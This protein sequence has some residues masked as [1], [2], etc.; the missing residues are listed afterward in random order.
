MHDACALRNA[1]KNFQICAPLWL[2]ELPEIGLHECRERM[3]GFHHAQKIFFDFFGGGCLD[4]LSMEG[5]NIKAYCFPLK[6]Y[7]TPKHGSAVAWV[8]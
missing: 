6:N 2:T 7:F 5:R 4:R 1:L 8:E 3:G